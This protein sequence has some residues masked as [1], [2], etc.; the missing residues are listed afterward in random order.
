MQNVQ[1]T[2]SNGQSRRPSVVSPND[3]YAYSDIYIA[4][5]TSDSDSDY[6]SQYSRE[7]LHHGLGLGAMEE[8]EVVIHTAGQVTFRMWDIHRGEPEMR[9][10]EAC[11]RMFGFGWCTKRSPEVAIDWDFLLED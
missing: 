4:N 7:K 11:K 8:D 6:D 3:M 9:A 2:H 1:L 5:S 10:K